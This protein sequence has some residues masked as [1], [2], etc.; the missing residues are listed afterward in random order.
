[1]HGFAFYFLK[2]IQG[3][4]N[5]IVMQRLLGAFSIRPTIVSTRPVY[6]V[7]LDLY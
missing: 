2:N 1:M 6:N 3:S 4:V 5:L 7:M